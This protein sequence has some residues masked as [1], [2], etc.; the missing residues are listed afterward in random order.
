LVAYVQ[1]TQSLWNGPAGDLIPQNETS[2]LRTIAQ[3][4]IVSP[5][6]LASLQDGAKTQELRKWHFNLVTNYT[7]TTGFV[8][9]FKLGG[10]YRWEDK[11]A[12]GYPTV[13]DSVS[14]QD[15]YDVGHPFYGPKEGNYDF[16]IGYHHKLMKKLVWSVDLNLKNA[17]AKR[18]LIPVATQPDGS[19]AAWRIPQPTLWTLTNRFEF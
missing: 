17:F 15:T 16:W 5:A 11:A 7:F 3:S 19:V 1:Q 12:I 14:G 9:G 13:R 18:D 8:K 2:N 10:A 6:R 4:E